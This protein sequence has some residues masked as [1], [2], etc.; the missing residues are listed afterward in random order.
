MICKLSEMGGDR[1]D[2]KR[3]TNG[4]WLKVDFSKERITWTTGVL[5]ERNQ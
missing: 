3:L 2:G 4:A 5:K 1:S